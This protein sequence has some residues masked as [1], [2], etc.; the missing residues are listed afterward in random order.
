M[1]SIQPTPNRSR[2]FRARLDL[3]LAAALLGS[4]WFVVLLGKKRTPLRWAGALV[5][6]AVALGAKEVAILFPLVVL[7]LLR[8]KREENEK[9]VSWSQ[10]LSIAWP[11][12]AAAVVYLITR[13]SILG[14]TQQLPE[15]SASLGDAILTAPAVFAFYLRQM[16][17]P[18]S[19]GPSYPLRAVT[20]DNIGLANFVIPLAVT[21]VAA[22]W[23]IRMAKRSK[24][25]R[26]GLALLLVPLLPAMYIVAF[27]PEQLVHDRYLYLPLLRVSAPDGPRARGALPKLCR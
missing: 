2:G 17:A 14:A 16:I 20:L 18:Y 26:V 5:L 1:P 10:A 27:H 23:M 22:W 8:N 11:F 6:Y 4:T 9:E 19:I 7:V 12:G 3:L 21:V 24:I 25:A 13:A 15:G